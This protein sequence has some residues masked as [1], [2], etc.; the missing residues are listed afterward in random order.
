[1]KI[2][3]NI[4]K[5][6]N[7]MIKTYLFYRFTEDNHPKYVKYFDEWYANLTP[8]QISYFNTDYIK[9]LN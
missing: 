6:N 3:F 5:N 7:S 8:N 2:L 1:M 4:C 9:S